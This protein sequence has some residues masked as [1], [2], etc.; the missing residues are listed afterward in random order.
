MAIHESASAQHENN[1][2]AHLVLIPRDVEILLLTPGETQHPHHCYPQ[3]W[4]RSVKQIHDLGDGPHHVTAP[5]KPGGLG[6]CQRPE[7]PAFIPSTAE[8]CDGWDA[9]RLR[10]GTT[11]RRAK[12]LWWIRQQ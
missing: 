7:P 4:I 5:A 8:N 3:L 2:L 6:S 10:H 11:H 12:H 9:H 1:L